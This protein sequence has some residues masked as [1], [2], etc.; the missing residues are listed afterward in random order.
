[1]DFD[2]DAPGVLYGDQ[3]AETGRAMFSR[4]LGGCPSIDPAAAPGQHSRNRTVR[5]SAELEM[6]LIRIAAQQNRRPTDVIRH[7]VG[8]HLREHRASA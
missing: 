2:P 3:D 1:M 8:E 6:Q 7:A 5:L 4:A